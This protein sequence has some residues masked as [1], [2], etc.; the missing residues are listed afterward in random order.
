MREYTYQWV[1]AEYT[2]DG[3]EPILK[4]T[5]SSFGSF[6]WCP[7]KYTF[8]Y[9][10]RLRQDQTE[11]MRKGTIVHNAREDFFNEFD[12]KKAENMSQ[13]E[14]VDYCVSLHP[15]DEFTEMYETMSIFEANRFMDMKNNEMP[16]DNFVPAANE[17]TL[18]A[19]IDV[20]GYKIHLQGIID[21]M[22]FED[23]N[24]IPFE[25]KTGLWKDYKTTSMRKEMA[26]YKLLYE[27][28]PDEILIEKGLEPNLSMS[29]WGWYYPASNY[30][31]VEPV[32]KRSET[33][34]IKGIQDLINAYETGIFPTKYF[35]KTCASCSFFNICE[36]ANQESWV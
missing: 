25:L 9:I 8:S 22:F 15:I 17:V 4:V 2:E 1:P 3:K 12:V 33:A 18:D 6:Q 32:K 14:L 27:N 36:A 20:S 29:H 21:R 11:A 5:K 16:L 31:L 28:C 13:R 19:E 24:Y 35:Y 7:R 34:V 10:D 23:G 26:F 30:V